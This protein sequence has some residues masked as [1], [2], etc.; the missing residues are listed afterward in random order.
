MA[1]GIATAFGVLTG[2]PSKFESNDGNMLV[3][4][5]GNNDWASVDG[6]CTPSSTL[7]CIAGGFAHLGDASSNSDD[8]F[9][10]GQK[11][12]TVCPTVEGH[13]NP[14]K[15]DFTHVASYTETQSASPFHTFLYGATIR[16]AANGNASENIELKQGKNGLCQGSTLLARTLGDKMIAIDY[17]GGGANVNFNV[18]TWITSSAGYD[19]GTPGDPSDDAA[20]TCFVGNDSPPCWSST[21][22]ALSQSAAEGSTNTAVIEAADN[23]ISGERLVVNKFAEFG[24]DLVAA[25]II[26]PNTCVSF[27]QT[28]W[29]SRSSGSSF[30]SSTKD[31]A[32]ENKSISNCGSIKIIKQTNPRGI[33]QKFSFTSNLPQ[34]TDAGGVAC[35]TGGDDGVAANGDFCLNDTGNAGKTLG[36]TD[37][38][39]NSTGN[40]VT[41]GNLFPGTYTVTE[42]ANP[43]GFVFD[44]VTCTGGTTS[45]NGKAVTITLGF[46]DNVVCVYQ[47]N[48]QLGAIQVSKES[49]KASVGALD[50]AKFRICTN[51]GP[52]TAQNPCAAAKTGSDDLGTTN[53]KVCVDGL[54]FGDY[55]VSEKSPPT[56]YAVDDTT[57]HKVTV[58]NNAK[59]SDDPFVGETILFK[60]TPLTDVT[61]EAKAQVADATASRIQCLDSANAHIGDSPDPDDL[62]GQPQFADPAKVT[63]TGLKPGTYVCT[64]VIDP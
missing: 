56:G 32:I 30:V 19:N 53:G 20:G 24:V 40:T 2:S 50:G 15:D 22:K 10:P 59:C 46:N 8:S 33:D 11:Q 27:P 17:L 43:T 37:A 12:D 5:A 35:T 34:N 52:Y 44:H 58:D 51:D 47:N 42:G 7:P 13:G 62:N 48:Q 21:V 38:A 14:N 61:V 29:E 6:T 54:S 41:E 60:D 57:V 31:I 3:T 26:P 18:L 25:G 23:S 1:F 36:S 16:V 55:Y 39:Q 28:V 4:T 45:V 49:I 63:A 64:V 9:E